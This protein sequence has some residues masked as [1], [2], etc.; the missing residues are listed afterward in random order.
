MVHADVEGIVQKIPDQLSVELNASV[1]ASLENDKL[2]LAGL[3]SV[4]DGRYFA[5]LSVGRVIQDALIGRRT[6]VTSEPF[7]HCSM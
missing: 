7:C 4:V 3:V 6:A 1:D 5:K 2:A